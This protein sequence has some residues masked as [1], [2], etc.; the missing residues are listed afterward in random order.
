[1]APKRHPLSKEVKSEIF[2]PVE[3]RSP[4]GNFDGKNGLVI[5]RISETKIWFLALQRHCIYTPSRSFQ[6][7]ITS[8]KYGVKIFLIKTLTKLGGLTELT[9]IE[10]K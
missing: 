5:P 9:T 10:Q 1:M 2:L 6:R 3:V 8:Q 7:G 4:D